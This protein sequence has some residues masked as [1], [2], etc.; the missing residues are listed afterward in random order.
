[1]KTFQIFV[2][3]GVL[4]LK[5]NIILIEY[6]FFTVLFSSEFFVVYVIRL[7]MCFQKRVSS[8]IITPKC[9]QIKVRCISSFAIT[10]YYFERFIDSIPPLNLE[11]D[12]GLFLICFQVLTGYLARFCLIIGISVPKELLQNVA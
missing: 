5:I 3:L 4:K 2:Y 8:N 12:M 10:M 1:M 6:F 11:V 9:I 7:C